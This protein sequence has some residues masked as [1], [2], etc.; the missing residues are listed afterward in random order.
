MGSHIR[1]SEWEEEKAENIGGHLEEK[2]PDVRSRD[3]G[4]SPKVTRMIQSQAN[5]KG[6]N[7][8]AVH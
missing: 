3:Q 8:T 7:I 1:V 2:Q 6:P 5:C 4:D